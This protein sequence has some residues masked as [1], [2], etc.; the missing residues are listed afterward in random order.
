MDSRQNKKE[1]KALKN[2]VLQR[3]DP[4]KPAANDNIITVRDIFNLLAKGLSVGQIEKLRPEIDRKAIEMGRAFLMAKLPDL[5]AKEI[6]EKPPYD[7]KMLIDENISARLIPAIRK[8]FGYATHTNFEGLKGEN[9]QTVW[10]WAVNHN[11]DALI[12]RDRK[13]KNEDE[14]LTLIAVKETL[15][16]LERLEPGRINDIDLRK[17]PT[18]IH[19]KEEKNIVNTVSHLFNKHMDDIHAYLDKPTSPYLLVSEE[20]LTPGPTY[21]ELLERGYAA[22]PGSNNGKKKNK[23]PK[24]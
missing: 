10:R 1:R 23:P 19:I 18:V 22:L 24:P 12:S 15:N 20:G 13:M 2:K 17:L 16:I 14:D 11:M 3:I 8:A 7:Y 6:A 4:D 9:D 21:K 5:Y